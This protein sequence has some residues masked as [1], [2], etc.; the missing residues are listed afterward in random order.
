[1]PTNDELNPDYEKRIVTEV[2]A[3]PYIASPAAGVWRK[4]LELRGESECGRVTSVVR[5]DAGARFPWHDH[6]GGEEILV[7]EGEFCDER[8]C[9][10]AGTYQLNPEGFSHAPYT[11]AGCLLF[12]KLRQYQGSEVVLVDTL[13]GSWAPRGL[14]GVRSLPLHGSPERGEYTRL[15]ELAPGT[16]VPRVEL[17]DGEELFVLRGA[18]SDEQGRYDRHTWL[19]LPAGSHH[20][21]ASDTGCLL[22]VKSGGFPR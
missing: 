8:G 11:P 3:M 7:L 9:F 17:P 1:M 15:T 5:F 2:D 19:R 4:R 22:Y 21:P 16:K 20:S 13:A 12:V 18:F 6:P 10:G 14:A